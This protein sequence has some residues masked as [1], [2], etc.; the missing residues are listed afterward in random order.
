MEAARVVDQ[1]ARTSYGRLVAFLS[2]RTR[3]VAAAEDALSDAFQAA[4][5]TW[6]ESGL[7]ERPEAWL[8]AVARRRQI[9][10]GRHSAVR[11]A[12]SAEL[13]RAAAQT[14]A[15]QELR[16]ERLGLMLL[17]AHPAS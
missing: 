3:D 10:D 9:D 2:S 5:T 16:D 11:Q 8:L 6:P 12:A 4:L 7:P 13:Q 17:C 1:V 15:G 14:E